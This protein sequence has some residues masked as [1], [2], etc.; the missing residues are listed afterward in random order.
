LPILFNPRSLAEAIGEVRSNNPI[1]AK[2]KE[3]I[4]TFKNPGRSWQREAEE[5][6]ARDFSSDTVVKATPDR[7]HDVIHNLDYKRING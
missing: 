2:K 5:V 7:I 1:A 4:G 3:L 6:N